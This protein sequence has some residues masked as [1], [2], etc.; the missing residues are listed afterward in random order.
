MKRLIPLLLS[1]LVLAAMVCT[2]VACD[3]HQHTYG[4]VW[5]KD[6]DNH[7]HAATCTDGEDCAAAKASV[8]AHA[9]SDN[10]RV[11]DVCGYDYDHTHTYATEYTADATSH[12]YAVTCGCTIEVNGK[13]AHVDTA[14]DGV[15]DVCAYDGGHTHSYVENAWAMDA[16]NHWRA[17][18]CGHSVVKDEEEHDLDDMG[19]CSVCGYL[20]GETIT[21]E[22]AVEM[23]DFYSDKVDSALINYRSDL[24]GSIK[25]MVSGYIIADGF[26]YIIDGQWEKEAWYS[27]YGDGQIFG[28]S[29]TEYG[30][31]LIYDSASENLN[32]LCFTDV[33]GA[34]EQYYGVTNLI[35]GLY[36]L[37][38]ECDAFSEMCVT[39][40][41]KVIY[42]FSFEC[43]EYGSNIYKVEVAFTLGEG[44]NFET[45]MITS[46]YYTTENGGVIEE[47][48]IEGEEVVGYEYKINTFIP[49]AVR[50]FNIELRK[51]TA[52]I[53]NKYDPA[54]L[55]VS[56]FEITDN[57]GTTV[58]D[59][60]NVTT[61]QYF[62]LK[63][64]A[65]A[66]ATAEL[67]F[68]ETEVIQDAWKV[69][70]DY[71]SEIEGF[72]MVCYADGEW[73]TTISINGVEKTF[74]VKAT[75]PAPQ[76]VVV[77]R[78]ISRTEE[79]WNFVLE[80]NELVTFYE[81]NGIYG[82]TVT[83]FLGVELYLGAYVDPMP[84]ANQGYTATCASDKVTLTATTVQG[85]FEEDIYSVYKVEASEAGAYDIVFTST[86]DPDV[87]TTVTVDIKVQPKI[88]DILN[89]KYFYIYSGWDYNLW[90]EVSVTYYVS[91]TP[92][93]DGATAGTVVITDGTNVETATYAY[94][95]L[96]GS[97]ALS[98]ADDYDGY[99]F[100]MELVITDTYA[101]KLGTNELTVLNVQNVLAASEWKSEDSF[102]FTSFGGTE[103]INTYVLANGELT[104]TVMGDEWPESN[105]I[106]Y[107]FSFE[108]DTITITFVEAAGELSGT[109]NVT[110]EGEYLD[111]LTI[112]NNDTSIEVIFHR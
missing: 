12:W 68:N 108:G 30:A 44:Y 65:I 5:A 92:E 107:E 111:K 13:A 104:Y 95:E 51:S 58:G 66:P 81:A 72:R 112:W 53:E 100:D 105:W 6:A 83:E 18:S 96:D 41:G 33:V 37:G 82:D 70:G 91:F 59:I 1:V 15:C 26:T 9:D 19:L 103:T 67:K 2:F 7:W 94:N 10:N 23:G 84:Y 52:P 32:G 75:A 62:I 55:L 48:I 3:A 87:S 40:D 86:E 77:E 28:V 24:V 27:V 17:A 46:E 20:E 50:E 22:K 101:L 31:E 34:G 16:E 73:D 21:V 54:E 60:I 79:M 102:E 43:V 63:A 61:G 109:M 47:A 35:T 93:S 39:V 56:S 4:D 110:V 71:D 85:A 98:Y 11:C 69:S 88:S 57:E 80:Q 78:Y 74:T 97:I 8:A 99:K 106:P 25:N 45:A 76:S 38:A 64:A 49:Y 14:N 42:V 29:E 89:G 36:E 90:A